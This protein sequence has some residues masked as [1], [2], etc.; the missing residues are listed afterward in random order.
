MPNTEELRKS[1]AEKLK[2]ARIKAGLTVTEA[3]EALGKNKNTVYS[4]E[5]GRILPTAEVFLQVMILYGIN[6][7][8]SFLLNKQPAAEQVEFVPQ[9]NNAEESELL[10][11]WNNAD[12]Q[13]KAAAK[14]VLQTFQQRKIADDSFGNVVNFLG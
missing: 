5:L 6:D 4:W 11:L 8:D 14:A 10:D 7:F 3:A 12:E 13:G 9:L 2:A 1:I